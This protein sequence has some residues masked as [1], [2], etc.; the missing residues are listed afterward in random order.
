MD[1]A[2]HTETRAF[3]CKPQSLRILRTLH[4]RK[5]SE[6]DS[7]VSSVPKGRQ[8]FHPIESCRHFSFLFKKPHGTSISCLCFKGLRGILESKSDKT[9]ASDQAR[10]DLK[11]PDALARFLQGADVRLARYKW[12]RDLM[13]TQR[14]RPRRQEADSET[15]TVG[16]ETRSAL[17]SYEEIKDWA[18]G[19]RQAAHAWET[20]EHPDPGRYQLEQIV[21]HALLYEAAFN[22][23]VWVFM[24]LFHSSNLEGLRIPSKSGAFDKP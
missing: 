2:F 1:T 20:R 17:V 15:F 23:E 14:P 22:A 10:F 19:T 21:S 7:T 6:K 12:L 4:R 24:I 16:G 8:C 3:N 5:A 13:S 18:S 11:D 9:E